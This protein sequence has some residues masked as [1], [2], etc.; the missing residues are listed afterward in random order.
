[1]RT[2]PR[3]ISRL[4]RAINP[5]A[6]AVTAMRV[7]HPLGGTVELDHAAGRLRLRQGGG[8]PTDISLA[9]TTISDPDL[10]NLAPAASNYVPN[11]TGTGWNGS[12]TTNPPGWLRPINTS[13]LT[14]TIAG[15]GVEDNIPY[16]D[17]QVS[18]T[19]STSVVSRDT[20]F[21]PGAPCALGQ[22]W[23]LSIH[24]RI[25][26]GSPAAL[27]Y[28]TAYAA[29][30]QGTGILSN[31]NHSIMSLATGSGSLAAQRTTRT[32]TITNEAA[33]NA[34]G[35]IRMGF[36]AD[37][38]TNFVYRVGGYH[39]A[40]DPGFDFPSPIWTYGAV[41]S[42]PGTRPSLRLPANA[43]TLN[44]RLTDLA[45]NA[46]EPLRPGD[47]L[48]VEHE[49]AGTLA[50]T[51][52][53]ADNETTSVLGECNV[54]L[55]DPLPV[56]LPI[57]Q[58]IIRSRREPRPTILALSRRITAAGWQVDDLNPSHQ[59]R[60]VAALL[61]SNGPDATGLLLAHTNPLWALMDAYAIELDRAAAAAAEA[62][63]QMVP[64]TADSEW[65]DHLGTYYG[66]PRLP[67]EPDE[68]Y[69]SRM[70]AEVLRPKSNNLAIASIIRAVTGQATQ[71]T[72][73]TEYRNP[74][75]AYD[76]TITHN[77]AYTHSATDQAIHGLF[78]VDTSFDILGSGDIAAYTAAVI[79]QVDRLR[80]AGTLLRTIRVSGGDI[81]ETGILPQP[82]PT[83]TASLGL[84]ATDTIDESPD[85]T[86]DTDL[87][88]TGTNDA[89]TP[90]YL[91]GEDPP[92][93]TGHTSD[94]DDPGPPP[95][96]TSLAP[97][98]ATGDHTDP[99]A[100]PDDAEPLPLETDTIGE[101]TG[102]TGDDTSL[103]GEAATANHTDPGTLPGDAEP[104]PLDAAPTD[105]PDDAPA[106]ADTSLTGEATTADHT[107]PTSDMTETGE[108]TEAY[109][110]T[111][112]GA[113][114]LNGTRPLASGSPITTSL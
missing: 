52:A 64:A 93:V 6:R 7:S 27:S 67:N 24:F 96:D 56:A 80:A 9:E 12:P 46:A 94:H 99:G 51:V 82:D 57:G 61:D 23:R 105:T 100:L 86:D 26:S 77:A 49:T 14:F 65:L 102:T 39:F 111:L 73:V 29:Q 33:D 103:T 43:G 68:T 106:A 69:A 2:R 38:P 108:L 19:A 17:I 41:R 10:G 84:A 90:A 70:V 66:V 8:P 101:E 1:M 75:P 81:A 55:R 42:R 91:P 78:D 40:L 44:L 95:D 54:T 45:P 110:H 71:V 47:T 4:Y 104:L 37:V 62:P 18:G 11:N 16:V 48:L 92:E 5:D 50:L 59:H 97:E 107:D 22:T 89:N 28:I 15:T 58:P 79:A 21:T 76:G 114:L 35:M 98:A 109:A 53:G 112:N 85:P 72:D 30:R 20:M 74:V 25:V 88:T 60:D 87:S 113:W 36:L 31:S 3:L 34:I 13:G 83:D 63:K 32:I